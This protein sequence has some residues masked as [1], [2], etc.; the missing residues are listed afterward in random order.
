VSAS[1]NAM[2]IGAIGLVHRPTGTVSLDRTWSR[3]LLIRRARDAGIHLV[4]ILELD[5][6]GRRSAQVLVRLSALTASTDVEVLLTDGVHP[7]FASA[8][9]AD[10]GVRHVSAASVEPRSQREVGD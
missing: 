3:G 8:L 10:L 1:V 4:D 9:A 5:D 2:T 6:D 7:D